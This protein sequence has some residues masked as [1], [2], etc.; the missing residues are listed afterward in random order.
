MEEEKSSGFGEAVRTKK[1]KD[2][3]KKR[4]WPVPSKLCFGTTVQ[5]T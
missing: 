4:A 2:K 5:L 3:E 1:R